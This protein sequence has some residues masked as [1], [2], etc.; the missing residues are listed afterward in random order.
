VVNAAGPWVDAIR[1]LERPAEKPALHLTKG[2]HLVFCHDDLPVRHCVVMRARD[3]RPV[4]AVPRGARVY[5]GT[6][7]TSYEGPLDEPAVTGEDAAYLLEALG[8]SFT[9]VGL[10]AG[11]VVGAWAGLRPLVH[12]EGKR[13]SE[14]S[15]KDEIAVSASGLVTIAG[16]KLTTYRRMAERAVATAAPLLGRE[17][18][19]GDS[20]TRALAGGDLGG[21]PDLAAYGASKAVRAAMADVPPEIA[22]RLLA[23]YGSDVLEVVR[24]AA[25]PAELASLAPGADLSAAEVRHA[26]RNEMARTIT[27]V[28]ER[29]S[30]LALMATDTARAVAPAVANILAA[31]LGW[32]PGRVD[33]ELATLARQADLR[34]AWR[35]GCAR[36]A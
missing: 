19:P 17:L 33:A 2:I 36:G 18:G 9:C 6:T 27:D 30:R 8:R 32:N 10:D 34:L 12:E 20:G 31:E 28:L 26:A 23:T 29:R 16:G 1:R 24:A 7:D 4:F 13:P 3:G 25:Q 15:R 21:A 5:V 22:S 35:E 11:H 14:I